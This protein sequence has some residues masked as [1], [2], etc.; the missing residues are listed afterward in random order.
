MDAE[1]LVERLEAFLPSAL[2]E[3]KRRDEARVAKVEMDDK[4][5]HVL[6]AALAA[7]LYHFRDR[8]GLEVDLV[9]EYEDGKVFLLE[10]KA[11]STYRGEQTRGI[12]TLADRVGDRFL[13]GAVL[14]LSQESRWLGDG[15]CGLPVSTLWQH[16]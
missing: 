15:I 10:V 6:A 1:V 4:D 11:S 2:V 3:V 7:T 9:L 14:G 5:R 13:G 12:R 8:D 16:P